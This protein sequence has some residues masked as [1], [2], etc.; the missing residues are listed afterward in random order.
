MPNLL[1]TMCNDGRD[2]LATT[3]PTHSGHPPCPG[4]TRVADRR[5]TYWPTNHRKCAESACLPSFCKV[6]EFVH[7]FSGSRITTR[8]ASHGLHLPA[9]WPY[10]VGPPNSEKWSSLK[11]TFRQN[12]TKTMREGTKLYVRTAPLWIITMKRGRIPEPCRKVQKL[13]ILVNFSTFLSQKSLLK[14]ILLP[15]TIP[16]PPTGGPGWCT[17]GENGRHHF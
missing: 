4:A 1:R 15:I 6:F 13:V 7:A 16:T 14:R 17:P 11:T 3:V 8:P 10:D 2:K 5:Y 12:A 9:A